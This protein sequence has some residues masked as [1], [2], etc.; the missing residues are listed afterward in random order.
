[1]FVIVK[2]FI[3]ILINLADS[4]S[5]KHDIIILRILNLGGIMIS[6]LKI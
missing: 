6:I 2:L 4:L 5:L 1:M 3:N